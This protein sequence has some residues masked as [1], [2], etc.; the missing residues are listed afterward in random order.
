M[1]KKLELYLH[2]PFCV[3]K[4]A[5]C[6]FLSSPADEHVRQ[7]YV[8]TLIM[9][10]QGYQKIYAANYE[11]TT[12]FLG[13]GTPS[14]LSGK[15][16][17]SIFNALYKSFNVLKEA[18]ITIEANPG[19][20][21]KEKLRLWRA[22][23]INRLSIGL[24]S[25]NNEELRML[26]RIHTYEDFLETYK[27]ARAYLFDNINIDL[28]SAIPG[29]TTESWKRTMSLITALNPEHISAYS[30]IIEE[31]T[32]FYEQYNN[33]GD[34]TTD[35]RKHTDKHPPI[36][37][38]D[39]ETERRIYAMTAD[40][41]ARLGYQRYEISNYAKKGFCCRHNQGYWERKDYLGIGLGASSLM[42]HTRYH[43]TQIYHNYIKKVKEG[44]DIR[45][46]I[47]TLTWADEI[48]EFMFLG[49]RET[50]GIS[51][52]DFELKFGKSI[53][54]IYGRQ[55]KKLS[56]GHLLKINNDSVSLTE[57]GIDVSNAVF[58]EFME[59]S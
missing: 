24:Q 51:I 23:G 56:E 2:I 25:A 21:S 45:E 47:E 29:Q 46:D 58:T 13:G 33:T 20:V 36:S 22:A 42:N 39:E 54:D 1:K 16:I 35:I 18:E 59:P 52:K 19:T 32:P 10:I 30:L 50:K 5:Y 6:D 15:Q 8:D 40:Y 12:I 14:I 41:L 55:L 27:M 57:R 31:G 3:K 26:G 17:V 28:I 43:N 7:E 9:E 37:L 34:G 49:L 4:C 44:I 11:V 48:E 38:P 53:F